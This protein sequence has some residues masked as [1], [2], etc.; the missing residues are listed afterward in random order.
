MAPAVEP[1]NDFCR[2]NNIDICFLPPHT[3]HALQPLDAGGVLDAYKE[4]FRLSACDEA[5]KDLPIS[6]LPAATQARVRWI[7][8]A[9]TAH[10][11]SFNSLTISR[12]F[13]R[14]GIYPWSID[15][16]VH[17]CGGGVRE[18]PSAIREKAG[19]AIR[20][21]K[22]AEGMRIANKPGRLIT[23]ELYLISCRV[24]RT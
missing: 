8:R 13:L 23:D 4:E 17:F 20:A 7:A 24:L 14:T 21:E 1:N 2:Q 3:A 9:L 19:E 16:F 11:L 12:G 5:L 6:L 10:M 18:L 22:E 15:R